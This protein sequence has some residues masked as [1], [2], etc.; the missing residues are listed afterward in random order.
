MLRNFK[1]ALVTPSP[2]ADCVATSSTLVGEGWDEG[3][4]RTVPSER[5]PS[6]RPSPIEGEGNGTARQ[7]AKPN[8]TFVCAISYNIRALLQ[9]I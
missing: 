3:K 2:P 5:S 4:V 8:L 1:V 7:V 6:P 9:C